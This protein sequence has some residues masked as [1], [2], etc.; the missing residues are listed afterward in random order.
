M[1]MPKKKMLLGQRG[2][3]TPTVL[4]ILSVF[5]VFSTSI[6]GWALNEKKNVTMESKKTKALQVAEAGL[7][8]YKWHLAHDGDDYRNGET[9]C[10]V[11]NVGGTDVYYEELSEC[12]N[13]CGPYTM[14]YDD[15]DGTAIG[16]YVLTITPY[17]YGSTLMEVE[18][19]GEVQ[20]SEEEKTV[21]ARMGKRSLSTYALLSDTNL[22]IGEDE[23]MIGPV[24]SNSGIRYD[25]ECSAEVTSA[26]ETYN[27]HDESCWDMFECDTSNPGS[28]WD[29]FNEEMDD[30]IWDFFGASTGGFWDI[31]DYTDGIEEVFDDCTDFDDYFHCVNEECDDYFDDPNFTDWVDDFNFI[32]DPGSDPCEGVPEGT[33]TYEE[34]ITIICIGD[35]CPTVDYRGDAI[36]MPGIWGLAGAPDTDPADGLNYPEDCQKYWEMGVPKIDFDLFAVDMSNIKDKAKTAD[37]IYL[38]PVL[39]KQKDINKAI[40]KGLTPGVDFAVV[41][42][43]G[44]RI[45]FKAD[46]TL[47]VYIVKTYENSEESSVRYKEDGGWRFDLEKYGALCNPVNPILSIP[48]NYDMPENGLIFVEDDVWVEGTVRGAATVAASNFAGAEAPPDLPFFA[49]S[50]NQ[51]ARITINDDILYTARDGSDVLGLMAEGDVL[52]PQYAPDTLEIDAMMLSQNGHVFTRNV[53]DDEE[54]LKTHLTVYGGIITYRSWSWN[55][56]KDGVIEE[57]YQDT[58]TEYDEHLTYSPPPGFPTEDNYEILSW[59]ED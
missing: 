59:R 35:G 45:V 34:E 27:C 21:T 3:I 32:S 25:N 14:A 42:G 5:L 47:D 54:V 55:Y 44:Y 30:S 15:R 4:I 16:Q 24:H 10:C 12:D 18:S 17:A 13:K 28:F 41:P 39:A 50:K 38:P 6:M 43:V 26:V 56:L 48:E 20:G 31:F 51:R 49:A 7:S 1:N 40:S 46:G 22:W 52:V 57:G 23:T 8:Y 29:F 9:W 36:D 33:C 37:G 58:L 2:M 53:A 19:R 11:K